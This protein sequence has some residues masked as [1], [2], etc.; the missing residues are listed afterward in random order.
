VGPD[1]FHPVQEE[2]FEVLSGTPV[3]RVDGKER[4][5]GPGDVVTVPVGVPHIFRNGAAEELHMIS[6]YRPGL[7]S[8][9]TF[10]ATFFGLAAEGAV[11]SSGR[12]GLL[13]SVLT[14]WEVRDYF[15]VTRPPPIVQRLLFPALAA[16]ARLRGKRSR[17]P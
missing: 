5:A 8:V 1:H 9:E 14:L 16:L 12:P 7:R 10:F 17:L 2:R 15:V 13:Q 11:N 4:A 3:F 6:E